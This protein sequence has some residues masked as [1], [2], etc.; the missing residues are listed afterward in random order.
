M[1][2]IANANIKLIALIAIKMPSTASI[3]FFVYIRMPKAI[4]ASPNAISSIQMVISASWSET[5]PQQI[6]LA[7]GI[8]AQN[9]GSFKE[10]KL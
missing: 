1:N 10:R 6:L 2:K 3:P 9:I 4:A 5:K 7:S 8:H